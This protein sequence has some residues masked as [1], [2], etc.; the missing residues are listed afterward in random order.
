MFLRIT[1]GK[2]YCYY[3]SYAWSCTLV[4][5]M[6][7]IFAHYALD[8]PQ[9]NILKTNSEEQDRIGEFCNNYVY[10]KYA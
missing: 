4:M 7:A 9:A 1:D 3:S 5:G 6:L 2:K 8:Y 10:L